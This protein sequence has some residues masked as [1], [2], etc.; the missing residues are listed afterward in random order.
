MVR[1]ERIIC[2]HTNE[3]VALRSYYFFFVLSIFSIEI[4]EMIDIVNR[5]VHFELF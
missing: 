4:A 3:R 5:L 2:Y 1:I